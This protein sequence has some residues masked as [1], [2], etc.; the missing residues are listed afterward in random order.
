M[1]SAT[2]THDGART[3]KTDIP[4]VQSRYC[5]CNFPSACQH[6]HGIVGVGV[7]EGLHV[8]NGTRVVAGAVASLIGEATIDDL[9]VHTKV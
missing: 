9:A 3:S 8:T 6:A 7:G 1:N 5:R 4:S 2:H